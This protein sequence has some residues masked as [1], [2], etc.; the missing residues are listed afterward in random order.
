MLGS[1]GLGLL[2]YFCTQSGQIGVGGVPSGHGVNLNFRQQC[3]PPRFVSSV[4]CVLLKMPRT[5]LHRAQHMP[6]S[7]KVRPLIGLPVRGA[8]TV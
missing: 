3:R 5:M 8:G 7:A 1:K 6:A 4:M 2:V